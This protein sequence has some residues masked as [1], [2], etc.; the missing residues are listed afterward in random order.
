MAPDKRSVTSAQGH[1]HRE[2]MREHKKIIEGILSYDPALFDMPVLY[3][4]NFGHTSPMFILPYG[5]MAEID[6]ERKSF[7][8]LENGVL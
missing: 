2:A 5:A 6:C 4:L 8:I 1:D 3:G 7:S